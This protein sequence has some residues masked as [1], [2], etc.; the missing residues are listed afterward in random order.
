MRRRREASREK[1]NKGGRGNA[2]KTNKQS[3]CPGADIQNVMTADP[4][5]CAQKLLRRS[6]NDPSSLPSLPKFIDTYDKSN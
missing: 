3:R 1:I 6:S 5:F 4:I 2:K